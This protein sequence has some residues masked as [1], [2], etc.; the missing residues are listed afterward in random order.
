MILQFTVF[1][2]TYYSTFLTLRK[3]GTHLFVKMLQLIFYM[4]FTAAKS[5]A[6]EKDNFMLR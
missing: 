5:S 2:K 1:Y 6:G 4:L 3:R